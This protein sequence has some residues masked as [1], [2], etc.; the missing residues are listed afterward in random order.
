MRSE[1]TDW[2]YKRE[3][4][5]LLAYIGDVGGIHQLLWLI[6]G[7]LIGFL[8]D[9]KFNARLVK[10]LYKVQ[11]YSADQSEYYK[12]EEGKLRGKEHQVL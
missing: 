6:G 2:Y 4:Y 1:S 3:T 7:L 8:V 10:E 5:D 11:Q 9:R 12:T